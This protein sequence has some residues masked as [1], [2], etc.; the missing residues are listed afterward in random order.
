MARQGHAFATAQ[1]A[2]VVYQDGNDVLTDVPA[3][4]KTIGEVVTRGNIV[5]KEANNL[6]ICALGSL[7]E[8]LHSTSVIRM[9]R[10]K[11]SAVA[12]LALV[13]WQSCT[14][15]EASLS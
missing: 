4:G 10:R 12:I 14:K 6:T 7:T 5:M 11:P 8:I 1:E 15:M 3:D 9:Q 2:R 13:T